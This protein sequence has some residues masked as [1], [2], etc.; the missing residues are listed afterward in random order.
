VGSRSATRLGQRTFDDLG[1]P[2]H[3]VTFCVLDLETTGGSPVDCAI[4]E[5]GAIKLRGGEP[6]GRFETLVNP[7]VPIPPLITVLTGITEAMVMPAPEIGDVLPHFLEFLSGS[8]IV[9]HNVRFDISFLDAALV[10]HGYAPLANTRV[11]TLGIARRLV[12]RDV[13]NLRLSTLARHLRVATEP[14][15][16]AMPDALATAE[17]F[18]ALLERAAAFGVLGLDDLLAL[19]SMHAHPSAAK[20]SLTNHLPRS[21]GVYMFH[22]RGG[23]LLYVG[24]A[25][26]LRSR[27]RSYFAQDDRRKIPQ[28]LRETASIT[29]FEC[30]DPLEAAVRELRLIQQHEPRF[31]RQGKRSR[32][33]AYLKLADE[34]LPR[35]TITRV[36]RADGGIYLGPLPSS[37]AAQL[38][39]EA[40]ETA[41]PLRRCSLR[42]TKHAP[43]P[44]CPT[45]CTAAQLGVAACPCSGQTS[46]PD[47][48]A[49]VERVRRGLAGQTHLLFEPLEARMRRFAEQER[50]E[51]AAATRNR[52]AALA[53]ALERR[54]AADTLRRAA[55]VRLT[56]DDGSA[57]D[58]HFGRLVVD[59]GPG[60]QPPPTQCPDIT[61]PPRR[62]EIDEMLILARALQRE[63]RRLR[64][65]AVDGVLAS[66]LPRVEA[67]EPVDSRRARGDSREPRGGAAAR[68]SR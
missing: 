16:R 42:V 57:L 54:D 47:Y 59:H 7:G 12:L 2:L 55:R 66:P 63:H 27:V 1:A 61:V 24:K 44:A 40:I 9:G 6:L 50:F 8:V 26:N 22:D 56:R 62:D 65:G 21:P 19:P 34:R 37:A 3:E 43:L 48:A 51:E 14:N 49:V 30:R 41:V 18:H 64:L 25:T 38:V 28:L 32:S 29:H 52:L 67:Y 53:R 13:P 68:R 11:D 39:K 4:T 36:A 35:L 58:V 15:H 60:A 31:N 45:P 5:I 10:A 46:E 20:L 17:V 23:R 33:Y